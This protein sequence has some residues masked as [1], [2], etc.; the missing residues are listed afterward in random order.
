MRISETSGRWT[1]KFSSIN[2][3][4]GMFVLVTTIPAHA[5][6]L[7][8]AVA[9]EAKVGPGQSGDKLDSR[10]P[11]PQVDVNGV[12]S[13]PGLVY[14]TYEGYRPLELDLYLP[15]A[16]ARSKTPRPLII[17]VHGGRFSMGHRRRNGAFENWPELLASIAKQ[18]YA[19]ASVSYRLSGEA[20]FPAPIQDIKA[21]I[22]WLRLHAE[23][24]DID[25]SRIAIWGA[26]AGG[27]LA[28][29]AG[30]SCGVAELAPPDADLNGE[31]G[32]DALS[33][34]DCV[35]A[36]VAWYGVFD[37]AA[38]TADS[39]LQGPESYSDYLVCGGDIRCTP[40]KLAF[41]SAVT[42]VDKSDP[43]FLIMH[44][45]DDT[46]LPIEQSRIFREKLQAAGVENSMVT[47]DGVGHSWIAKASAVTE[48][49]SKR[50]IR[51]SLNFIESIFTR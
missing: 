31:P 36:A 16:E 17:F 47:I 39:P 25:P 3:A 7:G 23:Q 44:G 42:Y 10:M 15:P 33:T 24:Y 38:M 27:A 12:T 41:P 46:I 6:T 20:G 11:P 1:M 34:S 50:A 48:E 29:L 22:R 45:T 21:A 13:L 40:D 49:A 51:T 43:P 30:T 2:Y 18:G 28:A 4:A 35:Q 14:A 26:S 9:R 19:T 5:E 8:D 32:A 37:H